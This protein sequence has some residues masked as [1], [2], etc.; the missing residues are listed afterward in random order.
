MKLY[1]NEKSSYLTNSLTMC[2]VVGLRPI[3]DGS[4]LFIGPRNTCC[5]G[6][7]LLRR[8]H[9]IK[10]KLL[11]VF[12]Q[13]NVGNPVWVCRDPISLILGTRFSL[14]LGSDDNFL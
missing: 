3:V 6:P 12:F 2:T 14:I 7:C 11:Q 13:E 8:L 10:H 4:A 1:T 5:Y 9:E